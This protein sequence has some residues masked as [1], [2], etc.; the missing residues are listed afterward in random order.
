MSLFSSVPRSFI[1]FFLVELKMKLGYNLAWQ[2]LD[3]ALDKHL[4]NANECE[5]HLGRSKNGI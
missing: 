5:L 2:I 1:I 4:Q 3:P